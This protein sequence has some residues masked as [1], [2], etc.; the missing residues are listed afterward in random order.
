MT[1]LFERIKRYVPKTKSILKHNLS[2]FRFQKFASVFVITLM[3]PV[4]LIPVA[5]KS[6]AVT[7]D[8]SKTNLKLALNESRVLAS[9]S[10]SPSILPGDSAT[11]KA[12][13]E[14]AAQA[15]A[16]AQAAALAAEK[17]RKIAVQRTVVYNDPSDFNAIYVAAGNA[18]GVSPSI[19]KAIHIV[20]TG[21][22]GSSTVTNHGGSGATGPMQFMPSTFRA[23]A[24]DG[25][26]DGHADINNVTDAIFTAAKYLK[27]CGYP[28]VQKALWGYNPSTSYYNRVLGIANSFGG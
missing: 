3:L 4:S 9:D 28:N 8:S 22:S 25:D 15:Q 16:Q 13:E 18:Y 17:A 21:G 14:A 10:Q 27:D 11:D 2:Y 19:L 26:G 7:S 12:A 5:D 23:H 6:N 20:E 24:V 1:L